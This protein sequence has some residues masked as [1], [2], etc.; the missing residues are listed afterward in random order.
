MQALRAWGEQHGV[1]APKIAISAVHARTWI[2]AEALEPGGDQAS[3]KHKRPLHQF[4]LAGLDADVQRAGHHAERLVSVPVSLLLHAEVGLSDPIYGNALTALRAEAGAE[5]DNRVML[6]LT[7]LLERLKGRHSWWAAYIDHLPEGY[8]AAAVASLLMTTT[9]AASDRRHGL[10]TTAVG[11]L[12]V[13]SCQQS[14]VGAA[15]RR[16]DMVG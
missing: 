6:V 16:P 15:R 12:R 11:A 14:C 3:T 7:L 4:I 1:A 10:V 8:G 9:Q 5:L 13:H 2:A